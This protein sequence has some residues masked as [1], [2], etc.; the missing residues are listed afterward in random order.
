[1]IDEYQDTNRPQYEL[2]LLLGGQHQNVC[3][4]GDED[5]SIYSWRGADIRNILEFERDFPKAKTI[6]LEQNYR[7]TQNILEAAS[8]VVANNVNRKGKSLWTAR[9]G[10]PRVGYYEAPDAE[11]EALFVADSISNHLREAAATNDETR[12]AV[13]YRTNAQSRLFEEALRRYQL[14]Y[15]VV[16][17]FSFY[18]RAEIKDMISYLKLIQNP[19][20]SIALLR[21]INTPVRGIG[22]TTV[23]TVERIALET[24]LSLRAAIGHAIQQKLL[25]ARA[26]AGLQNFKEIIEDARAMLTGEFETRLTT[27][28]TEKTQEASAPASVSAPDEQIAF[29]PT[30]FDPAAFDPSEFEGGEEKAAEVPEPSTSSDREVGEED[31]SAA[32]PSTAAGSSTAAILKF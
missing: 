1:M 5:Q 15:N 16:G 19:D 8:A 25:P 28:D 32:E 7:S 12:V 6:R 30:A 17:G 31:A 9:Q 18:E 23:E 10:G 27:E 26:L 3:V 13:L 2:M 14:K 22:K 11:N 24:G 29:D 20:D 4:V 21:V